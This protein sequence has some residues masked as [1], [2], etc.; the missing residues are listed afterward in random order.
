MS[1]TQLG[2]TVKSVVSLMERM[3]AALRYH[4]L[5]SGSLIITFSSEGHI[6]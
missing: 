6:L 4:S 2:S 3:I 5:S 1:G